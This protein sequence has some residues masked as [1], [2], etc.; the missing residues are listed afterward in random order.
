MSRKFLTNINLNKNELQNAVI[1]PL[2]SAPSSPVSGQVYF[3]TT[4]DQFGVYDGAEWVY[5]GDASGDDFVRLTGN[6]TVGGVKTFTQFPVTPGS[7]PSTSFQVANKKYVDDSIQQAGGYTDK[8]AEDAVGNI[9]TDTDT[10]DFTYDEAGAQIRADVLDS[11]LLNGEDASYYLNR[12]NHTGTQAASTISNFQTTVSSNTDVAANTAAR[13]THANKAVL[14]ATTASYTTSEKDKLGLISVT[15]ATDLD[16]IRT[17]VDSLDAVVVLQGEWEASTG[18]FPSGAQAGYS[19]IVSTSGSVDG[20]EFAVGDRLLAIVDSPSAATYVGNWLKLDYTDQVLSVNGQT[21]AVNITAANIGLGNVDNTPDANKPISTATQSALDAKINTSARGS[22][23]G[24][25][26]LDGS[27]NVPIANI[28]TGTSGSTVA[29]GNHGHAAATTTTA[30]FTTLA[31]A[32][33]ANAKTVANKSVTPAALAGYARKYTAT[34]GGSTSIAVA[35][36]LGTQFV[37]A[38]AY[39]ESTGELVECDITLTSATQ[40]TF[41]FSVAPTANSIRVVITG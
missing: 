30:G 25:A 7:A 36:G 26:P 17:R 39:E 31:T 19:Y 23:N 22:A 9:L 24:V 20:V 37:T 21:G 27:S 14:D 4:L 18:A 11:P 8:Q 32:A 29:L 16:E 13:H 40:T 28:P 38:Q 1:Q 3:D 15:E 5:M 33:E 34:I 10:V 2:A 12:A 6:Q 41:G 35:H